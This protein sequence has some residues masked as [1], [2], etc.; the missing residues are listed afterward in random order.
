MIAGSSDDIDAKKAD[1]TL[2]FEEKVPVRMIPKDGASFDFQGEPGV[3]HAESVHDGDG[4]GR[5]AGEA[6]GT[7]AACASQ[8]GSCARAVSLDSFAKEAALAGCLFVCSGGYRLVPDVILKAGGKAAREWI[9]CRLAAT[10][11][12]ADQSRGVG[13]LK[14]SLLQC[15]R[16][17]IVGS[18]TAA[19]PRFRTTDFES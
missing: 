13:L 11:R 8:T 1:I 6:S 18:L 2:K 4:E 7:Q 19:S 12:C 14:P 5:V 9:L 10:T 15:H 3:L 16:I 17:G